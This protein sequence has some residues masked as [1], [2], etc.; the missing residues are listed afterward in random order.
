[1]V[2]QRVEEERVSLL[3]EEQ[4]LLRSLL[5]Q[6]DSEKRRELIYDAFKPAKNMDDDGRICDGAPN[7]SPPLFINVARTFMQVS[8]RLRLILTRSGIV[9]G[10]ILGLILSGLA[11]LYTGPDLGQV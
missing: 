7:I 3:P 6:E 10:L 5:K 11:L 9:M 1:M 4:K 8:A 2:K